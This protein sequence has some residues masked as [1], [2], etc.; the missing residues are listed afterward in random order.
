[1]SPYPFVEA[2]SRFTL[3]RRVLPGSGTVDILGTP[4]ERVAITLEA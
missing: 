2:P 3:V 1:V 4:P